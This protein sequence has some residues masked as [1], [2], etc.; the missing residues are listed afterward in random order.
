MT[1]RKESNFAWQ[2]DCGDMREGGVL[3]QVELRE[4]SYRDSESLLF[5][6]SL[7]EACRGSS[8]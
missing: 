8:A 5:T 6:V 2:D 3:L 1:A 4:R 7:A